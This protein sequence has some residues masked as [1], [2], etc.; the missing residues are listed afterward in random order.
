[1]K[2]A[3]ILHNHTYANLTLLCT[4]TTTFSRVSHKA[5]GS[6]FFFS[7]LPHA[8]GVTRAE[9]SVKQVLPSVWMRMLRSARQV[10][11]LPR[12]LRAAAMDLTL[13]CWATLGCFLY[14]VTVQCR[15]AWH[16]G[17]LLQGARDSRSPAVT[18]ALPPSQESMLNCRSGTCSSRGNP[19]STL[20]YR[21]VYKLW[22]FYKYFLKWKKI[23]MI[24]Y[25]DWK[26]KIKKDM[27]V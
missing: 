17:A 10:S 2:S 14:S 11:L 3:T 13:S 19:E 8:T 6:F 4:S 22:P 9:S 20:T 18:P 16:S 1:M 25:V 12:S 23:V 26:L 5:H 24:T 15:A 27:R 21:R 7:F